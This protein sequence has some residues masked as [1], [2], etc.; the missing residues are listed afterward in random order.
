MFKIQYQHQVVRSD[1]PKLSREW[2]DVIKSV[3]EEK[4]KNNPNIYSKPLRGSLGGYWK[5]RVGD[6]R[7]V[8]KIVE[9]TVKI[10]AIQHR[11]IVYKNISKRINQK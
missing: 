3:I 9:K 8:F 1:I 6:Y 7:I 4:L 11:S 10:F 2:K 5:L